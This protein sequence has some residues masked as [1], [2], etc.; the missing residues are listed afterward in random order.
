MTWQ[1]RQGKLFLAEGMVCSQARGMKANSLQLLVTG[2]KLKGE[3]AGR[4]PRKRV[5]KG[6]E[7]AKKFVTDPGVKGKPEGEQ[8]RDQIGHLGSN[9]AGVLKGVGGTHAWEERDPLRVMA[10]VSP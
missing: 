7:G 3:E 1:L 8:P 10:T 9:T 2:S 4:G 5:M 6:Q